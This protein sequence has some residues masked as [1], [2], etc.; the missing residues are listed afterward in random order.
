MWFVIGAPGSDRVE[1]QLHSLNYCNT[2]A[3]GGASK[4]LD[5]Y[6]PQFDPRLRADT[7]TACK[8]LVQMQGDCTGSFRPNPTIPKQNALFQLKP[9]R[10]ISSR[11]APQ[12]NRVYEI[13]AFAI[14]T[15]TKIWLYCKWSIVKSHMLLRGYLTIVARNLDISGRTFLAT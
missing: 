15:S 5:M 13:S 7:S 11:L 8:Y 9:K 12:N 10:D 14:C 1:V 3:N 6:I 4:S 2:A